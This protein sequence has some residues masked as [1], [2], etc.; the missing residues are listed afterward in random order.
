[1]KPSPALSLVEDFHAKLPQFVRPRRLAPGGRRASSGAYRGS[2]CRPRRPGPRRRS[3]RG[4]TVF[5]GSSSSSPWGDHKPAYRKRKKE[6]KKRSAI[7]NDSHHIIRYYKAL[8]SAGGL[9]R[10]LR[11]LRKEKCTSNYAKRTE[12]HD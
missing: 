2:R 7:R 5:P 10:A 8:R 3:S 12:V 9:R 4:R 11:S 6:Q 1:M